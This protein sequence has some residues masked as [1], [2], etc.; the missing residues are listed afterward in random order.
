MGHK[1]SKSSGEA[2]Q[3]TKDEMIENL[4]QS[5]NAYLVLDRK[6]C[7]VQPNIHNVES[8]NIFEEHRRETI[9][10]FRLQLERILLTNHLKELKKQNNSLLRKDDRQ[11]YIDL[12]KERDEYK[13]LRE[14]FVKMIMDHRA[15][16]SMPSLNQPGEED[17]VLVDSAAN[18]N[19]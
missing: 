17:W 15:S 4:I 9:K 11:L 7:P 3:D 12:S 10:L 5:F 14:N 1:R 2:V 16:N 18:Q 13:V 19:Q 8:L 6:Y